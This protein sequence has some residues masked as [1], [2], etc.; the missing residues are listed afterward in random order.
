MQNYLVLKKKYLSIYDN[1][2]QNHQNMSVNDKKSTILTLDYL[3]SLMKKEI[4]N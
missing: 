4:K 1:F 3:V 2:K